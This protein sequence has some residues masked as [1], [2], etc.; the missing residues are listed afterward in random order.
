MDPVIFT[1]IGFVVVALI[2]IW[3]AIELGRYISKRT[4]TPT[5]RTWVKLDT[6]RPNILEELQPTSSPEDQEETPEPSIQTRA[7]QNG[8]H[9]ESR[10]LF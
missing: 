4:G 3:A 1:Y 8:H 7:K 9:S 6:T 2:L 5:K 10:Q